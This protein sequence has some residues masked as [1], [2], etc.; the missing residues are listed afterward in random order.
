[1]PY[2]LFISYSRQD[3]TNGRIG[4][5]VRKI[6]ED[7]LQFADE[8]LECFFDIE[9]I[10]G[11]EDWKHRILEG[12]RDSRLLL[13]CLS[14]TYL[15]REYCAWEFNEYLKYETGRALIGQGVAPVY[16]VEIPGWDDPGFEERAAAW[17]SELRKRQHID[18]RP[19]F[20]EGINALRDAAVTRRLDLLNR[21]IRDRLLHFRRILEMPGN[22]DRPNERFV[23]RIEEMRRLHEMV[24]LGKIGVLTAIHGL[25]G[26]GK[27]ALAV[28]YAHAYADYYAGGRWQIRCEGREDLRSAIVSLAGAEG[29]KFEFTDEQK[30]DLDAQFNRTLAEMK[31]RTM[32]ASHGHCLIIL[33]N[34]DDPRLLEPAMISRLPQ[35]EWLHVIATSR[36]GEH[37]LYGMQPDRSFLPVDELPEEDAISLMERY[38]PFNRFANESKRVAAR[39]IVQLLGCLTLAV[40]SAAVYLGTYH[41]DVTCSTFLQ[42]LVEEGLGG[43]DEAADQA[44]KRTLHGEMR[45]ST[46]LQST[47]E[48][49]SC[50]E[51]LVLMYAALFPADRIALPWIRALVSQQ[52]PKMALEARIG[53]PDPWINLLR[54]LFSLR[55]LQCIGTD[56]DQKPREARMHRLVQEVIQASGKKFMEKCRIDKPFGALNQELTELAQ[57][58]ASFLE[59]NWLDWGHRWEVEPLREYSV[60][61]LS[62]EESGSTLLANSVASTLYELGRYSEAEP[63]MRRALQIDETS[64][65]PDHPTVAIDLNNLAQLLKDT[66]RLTEAEPLMRRALQ[67][68][69]TSY[70]PDHPTVAIDLNNLA[71]L[72]K[73]TNRLTEAEPLMRRALQIDETSYGPDHPTVAI[74]LNNLAQL[75][76]DTNRLTEAEPLMR[77]ALQ[78]DETSYGPDH[79]TV[80]RDLNNLALLL[81]DTN[82]LTEAEPLMRGALQIAETSYGPEHPTVAIELNNLA[83]LL[84]DTNRLTEAEPLILLALQIDETSYGPEHPMVARDLNNLALLLKDTNRLTEAEPLMRRALSI[85]ETSYGPEHPTV[86]IDLNNL[87]LLLKDTNR[88]TEAE[89]LMRRALQ[90]DETSYGPD[91]PT[92]AIDLNNLA[93]LLKDTNRL[94]E[95]EPLM[96]RALQIDET[97]YGPDHPTV[98]I[99]L[100]NLAQLLKATNRLTE[101]EPLMRRALVILVRS[102]GIEHPNSKTLLYKYTYLLQE[103]GWCDEKINDELNKVTSESFDEKP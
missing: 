85:D 103:T 51:L 21:Q 39:E 5:F 13:V 67:I 69:E 24:G 70:G 87:A 54:H 11:M 96:R 83:M 32:E 79:P 1:M 33:D 9:D 29:L 61:V 45:I 41:D 25:G 28:Q 18:L 4:D 14:P 2:D 89:P 63:L 23:G 53:Y 84:K 19:W 100:N 22:V 73:D 82:R 30:R 50:T 64:Y 57:S 97:S 26:M 12:L 46:T 68:D 71:Q 65:G 52:Y 48:R 95:A 3:N 102:F 92:V 58:R 34:V 36:L 10:H 16:F 75:L 8:E 31:R 78:I 20:S 27:T 98:A 77:R 76:K 47:L 101:A 66:N 59:E 56:H 37:E 93:Q 74:D 99:D 40:E 80:A 15:E 72:L 49:L 35:E 43:L 91:H 17:V 44:G 88:L 6:K 62:L 94:T 90:I 55:L 86:A 60:Q 81:Q 7:Y 38:Q 42:R